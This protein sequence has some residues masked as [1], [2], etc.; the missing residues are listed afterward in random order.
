MSGSQVDTYEIKKEQSSSLWLYQ[1]EE[2]K[3]GSYD[4]KAAK[5]GEPQQP[6]LQ[7][8]CQK[9]FCKKTWTFKIDLKSTGM[10]VL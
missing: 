10:F 1:Q 3:P 5:A 2:R 8:Q 7:V 4:D 6:L 9:Y